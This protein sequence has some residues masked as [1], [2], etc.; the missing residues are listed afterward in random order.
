[1]K[2]NENTIKAFEIF[3]EA[4]NEISQLLFKNKVPEALYVMGGFFSLCN[5]KI[6]ELRKID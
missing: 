3:K 6:T 4:M 2:D 5:Q 1:M